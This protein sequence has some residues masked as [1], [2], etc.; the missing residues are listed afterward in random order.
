MM[1][2]VTYTLAAIAVLFAPPIAGADPGKADIWVGVDGTA[3]GILLDRNT[4]SAWM[5][6]LCLKPLQTATRVDGQWVS[7]NRELVSVGRGETL[8]DQTFYVSDAADD[9]SLTIYNPD[10]GGAQRISGVVLVDCSAD[11]ACSRFLDTPT[12]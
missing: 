11:D 4:R 6:G 9:P 1:Q 2:R 3:D 12:C 5:T 8:L 7:R 10:R